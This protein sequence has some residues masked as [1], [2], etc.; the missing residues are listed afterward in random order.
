MR[1]CSYKGLSIVVMLRDEHCP[2]HVHV[3]AGAWNARLQFSFWHNDIEVWD[4]APLSCR[5][6]LAVLEGLCQSLEQPAHLR[7]ARR[8]WWSRLQTVCLD[9]KLWD[10][11]SNQVLGM[12]VV[13]HTTYRVGSARYEPEGDKTFLTLI[14]AL[15]GVEI[16]L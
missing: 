11:H 7:R 10:N 12:K 13:T 15:E 8:I 5:P 1:V 14:G 3:N 9:N 6:P 4:V 16:N 2:P